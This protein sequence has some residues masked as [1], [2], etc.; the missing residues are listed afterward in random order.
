MKKH[1]LSLL[2]FAGSIS[3]VFSQNLLTE[4]ATKKISYNEFGVVNKVTFKKGAVAQSSSLDLLKEITGETSNSA[5][6]LKSSKTD[7]YNVTHEEF[8]RTYNGIPIDFETYKVHS[9]NGYIV[10]ANGSFS[11]IELNANTNF[12]SAE[13][14]FQKALNYTNAETYA[15]ETNETLNPKPQPELVILPAALVKEKKVKYA[16]KINIFAMKPLSRNWVYV[17]AQT[18]E[19]LFKDPIIKHAQGHFHHNDEKSGA[20]I[21]PEKTETF[22]VEGNGDTRYSGNQPLETTLGEDELY[23]LKDETRNIEVLNSNQTF[24]SNIT[25]FTDDDNVWSDAEFNNEFKDNAAL[26]VLWGM[27]KTYDYF[28]DMFDRDSYDDF[29]SPLVGYVHMDFEYDNAFWSGDFMGYGDGTSNGEEGNGRF[30]ALVSVDVT[31]HEIGHGV[32]QETAGL[33]Y[34][35]EPGALNESLS[36]IWGAAVEYFAAPNDL[37]KDRWLIGEEIDRRENSIALRSMKNPKDKGSPNTYKG[38]YW[39]PASVEDGCIIPDY[40]ENDYCGVHYNSGVLN[41]WFYLVSEGGNG[42]NDNDD[43]YEVEGIGIEKAAAIVYCAETNYLE[44][45]SWYEDAKEYMTECAANIFGDDTQEYET[46]VNAWYAV[47]LGDSIMAVNEVN[48]QNILVYPNPVKDFINVK[49][50]EN[51]AELTFKIL[52]LNGQKLAEGK[53][54]NGKINTAYLVPGNYVLMINGKNLNHT[55]KFIKK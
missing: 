52:N 51:S 8:T 39:R 40:Y 4:R 38:E 32:C 30:D 46:V 5:F 3:L 34:E 12:I 28:M 44:Y 33:I 43:A 18:G 13:E 26:D 1:L 42:V 6:V 21:L 15:W 9:K 29:G 50:K 24:L 47:G 16:Y 20:F 27:G 35:R 14:A 48:S 2:L 41:Y 31:A 36:D 23:I 54:V 55:Q 10:S 53:I 25:Q 45:D 37:N 7:K 22:L 11:P 17:D 49:V 19:I